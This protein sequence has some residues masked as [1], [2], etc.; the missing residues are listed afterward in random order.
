MREEQPNAED[1]ISRMKVRQNMMDFHPGA[2]VPP[3][4]KWMQYYLHPPPSLGCIQ[5]RADRKAI[6]KV[7]H[8][9][10]M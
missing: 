8:C 4:V 1:W 7:Q 2:S 6:C 9:V 10:N 5:W 3:S